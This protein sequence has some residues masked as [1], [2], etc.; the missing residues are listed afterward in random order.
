MA[1]I[2]G[3]MVKGQTNGAMALQWLHEST[4]QKAI[5]CRQ[6]ETYESWR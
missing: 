4:D 5:D 1:V 2:E 6:F 3:L